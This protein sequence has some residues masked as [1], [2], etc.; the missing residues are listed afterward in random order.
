ME[1]MLIG[2][3]TLDELKKIQSSVKKDASKIISDS[4]KAA[5]DAMDEMLSL[6][7]VED[8]DKISSLAKEADQQLELARTVSSISDVTYY[9]P[10]SSD[11][12]SDGYYY[13]IENDNFAGDNEDVNS[14][15]GTLE[16]MEYTSRQWHE[17]RC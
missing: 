13:K 5:T 14:L 7:E 11:Y 12:D 4:I 9:L 17:S 1:Q 3:Y 2:G 8:I 6:D 16:D 10:Y 15:M